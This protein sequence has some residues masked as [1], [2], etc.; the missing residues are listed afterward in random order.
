MIA[1]ELLPAIR[2]FFQSKSYHSAA[3]VEMTYES[4]VP[5]DPRSPHDQ[6]AAYFLRDTATDGILHISLT[7][8]HVD[9]VL[10]GNS[11]TPLV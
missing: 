7:A 1:Q 2:S 8:L 6:Q 3:E 11:A 10:T 9:L 4:N 5:S